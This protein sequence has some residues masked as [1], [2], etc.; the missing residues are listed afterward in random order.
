MTLEEAT[1]ILEGRAEKSNTAS[2][3]PYYVDIF[4]DYIQDET[5]SVE[6]QITDNYV[7]S[8]YSI[9]DHIAIKP[10]VY[11]LRGCVGEVIFKNI[12]NSDTYFRTFRNQHP[13][14]K[15]TLE[16]VNNIGAL[17][18]TV[19]NYTQAAINITKQI[20]SSYD[21]YKQIYDNF[22]NQTNQYRGKRQ[23][24]C[25]DILTNMLRNR[26]PV[27]IDGLAFDSD[28]FQVNSYPKTFF[29]QSVSA[30]QGDNAF[31]SDIEVTIKEFR[32]ATTKTTQI[33]TSKFAGYLSS[34]TTDE[35][36]NGLAK[37]D[38]VSQEQQEKAIEELHKKE[39][40][41]KGAAERVL[42]RYVP[43]NLVKTFTSAITG[44]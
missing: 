31:I 26:I 34:Q 9:Q 6:A 42:N 38:T 39:T 41:V 10:R 23:K 8:N 43:L 35:S 14:L 29:I 40:S 2:T 33:D 25:Y 37:G 30:H 22:R 15:K 21:R 19:S 27:T 24:V 4:F 1:I 16:T 11:R 13:I 20:E 18:G 7:E 32:I 44:N 12:Y 28:E 5:S 17:S 36:N 3:E